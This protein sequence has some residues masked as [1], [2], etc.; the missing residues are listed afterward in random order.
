MSLT[1]HSP[2]DAAMMPKRDVMYV[3]CLCRGMLPGQ[4]T[5]RSNIDFE[6]LLINGVELVEVIDVIGYT[7][8]FNLLLTFLFSFFFVNPQNY[9]AFAI[10]EG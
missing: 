5:Q 2:L 6:L 8:V 3:S 4:R 9:L 7:S 1:P 10:V